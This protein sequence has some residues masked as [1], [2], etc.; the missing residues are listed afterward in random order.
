M[1]WIHKIWPQRAKAKSKQN[2]GGA[3]A[4]VYGQDLQSPEELINRANKRAVR[5]DLEGAIADFDSAIELNPAKATTF[6]NRAYLH[7]LSGSHQEAIADCSEAI[8]LLPEYDE[9]FYQRGLAKIELGNI[10]AALVDLSEVLRLNPFSIKAYYKRAACYAAHDDIQGA[11]ADYTQAI[12]RVPKDSNAYLQRGLFLTKLKEYQTAVEDFSSA[13]SFNPKS[14]EAYYHRG[15][16]YA[17]LGEKEKATQDFNQAMLYDPSQRVADYNRTYALGIIKEAKNLPAAATIDRPTVLQEDEAIVLSLDDNSTVIDSPPPSS[18]P[19]IQPTTSLQS[20]ELPNP[21]P[22]MGM[23]V[24]QT[25]VDVLFATGQKKA[26]SGDFEG[27][28]EAYSKILD[29][30]PDNARAHLERGKSFAALGEM[31]FAAEDMDAAVHCAK[32]KSL[33]LMQDYRGTLTETLTRLKVDLAKSH[34][35][36][37]SEIPQ[38][39]QSI[40][41]EIIRYSQEIHRNPLSAISYFKRAQSR[42]LLGD[43]DGAIADYTRTISLE[44]EHRDAYYKRGML[45]EALGDEDGAT[46]DLNRAIRRTPMLLASAAITSDTRSPEQPQ[47]VEEDEDPLPIE[48]GESIPPTE[49][50]ATSATEPLTASTHP[51]DH[52]TEPVLE[53]IANHAET[54]APSTISTPHTDEETHVT[55]YEESSQQGP[56]ATSNDLELADAIVDHAVEEAD[57]LP[58]SDADPFSK[59]KRRQTLLQSEDEA[60]LDQGDAIDEEERIQETIPTY[61]SDLVLEPCTHEGNDPANRFCVHCGQPIQHNP[62]SQP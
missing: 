49:Q 7:N 46:E 19:T 11:V 30:E 59:M 33:T 55:D 27:A 22:A 51:A 38:S 5:G 6:Y 13:L 53:A 24:R 37:A 39:N 25:D 56:I 21:S 14:A 20:V 34:S 23:L 10:D 61:F 18:K 12:L 52:H 43:L 62:E 1:S 47:N 32:Q 44:P 28:I 41:S 58:P 50:A 29:Y 3:L 35:H 31:D 17:E 4:P 9:A 57:A 8:A 40:E 16:C 54:D 26:D 42:A 36:N 15:Y 60:I 2:L 48:T 45:L